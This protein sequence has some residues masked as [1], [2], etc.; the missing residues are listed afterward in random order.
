MK[1]R[2]GSL[3]QGQAQCSTLSAACPVPPRVKC[4]MYTL[5]RGAAPLPG[6]G[7]VPSA[8]WRLNVL[9]DDHHGSSRACSTGLTSVPVLKTARD[10]DLPVGTRAGRRGCPGAG[11]GRAPAPV[12][13]PPPC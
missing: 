5:P 13:L 9:G 6:D 10:P 2:Q 11:P 4:R 3:H 12:S 8:T 1:L 7:A